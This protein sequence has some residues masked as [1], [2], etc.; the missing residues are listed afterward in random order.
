MRVEL[1]ESALIVCTRNRPERAS[2]LL[3]NLAGMRK[4]PKVIVFV[5]SSEATNT[6]VA[7][8]KFSSMLD[9]QVIYVHSDSGAAH[10]KNVGLDYIQEH[11]SPSE[12]KCIHFLDDDIKPNERYFEECVN[13]FLSNENAV[14]I[15]GFDVSLVNHHPAWYLDLLGI[16]AKGQTGVVLKSGVGLVP[17]PEGLLDEVEWV[18]GGMQNIRWTEA[19]KFRFDGRVRIYGDEVELHLRLG[20]MGKI[21]VSNALGVVHYA[22]KAAKDNQRTETCF[23]DGFRWNL[24]RLHP[25]RVSKIQVLITTFAFIAAEL[26]MS[27]KKSSPSSLSRMRGHFDFLNLLLKGKQVQQYVS[28]IGSGPYVGL[29][30]L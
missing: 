26:I 15:G 25:D 2:E 16:T 12:F 5:D 1:L 23:M 19:R 18:P 11:Y 17:F 21:Y 9:P 28:H 13:L 22:E 24:S 30:R 20:S 8:Q 14:V 3:A 29:P 10:Q 6:R 27:I 4:L 7:V